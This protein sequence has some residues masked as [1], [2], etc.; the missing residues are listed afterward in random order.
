MLTQTVAGR[1]YDYDYN[2]G[3]R[4]MGLAIS[5]AFGVGDA[6]YVLSRQHEQLADVPWNKTAVHAKVGKYEVPDTPGSEELLFR[7][8]PVR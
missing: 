3:S 4:N 7:V 8:R 2:V 5:V 6:I 1:T